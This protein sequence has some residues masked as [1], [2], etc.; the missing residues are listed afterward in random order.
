MF[1]YKKWK[2]GRAPGE[3]GGKKD[4]RKTSTLVMPASKIIQIGE[5]GKN[6]L[7]MRRG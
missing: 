1:L 7:S 3:P 2:R 6:S 4:G 5:R